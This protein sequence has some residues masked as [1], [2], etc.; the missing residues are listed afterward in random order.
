MMRN[1]V[2][3]S[4]GRNLVSRTAGSLGVCAAIVRGTAAT[5]SNNVLV[6]CDRL[7][8]CR[9]ARNDARHARTGRNRLRSSLPDVAVLLGQAFDRDHALVIRGV[10]HDDAPGLA[11]LDAD[12]HHP[13]PHH[14]TAAPPQHQLLAFPP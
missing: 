9:T 8:Q 12:L 1:G 10:E 5:P 13:S 4:D 2:G 3:L 6:W 11:P 7:D 14:L